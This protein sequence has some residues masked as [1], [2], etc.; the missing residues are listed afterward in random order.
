MIYKELPAQNSVI[1]A[2]VLQPQRVQLELCVRGLLGVVWGWKARGN[3]RKSHAAAVSRP[4]EL[5][6]WSLDAK[7][8]S[9]QAV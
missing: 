1:G 5:T 7:E 3:T 4:R 2:P 6:G 9:V 8:H